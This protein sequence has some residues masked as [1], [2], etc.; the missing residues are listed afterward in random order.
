VVGEHVAPLRS[1]RPNDRA[2][3]DTRI[4]MEHLAE[5]VRRIERVLRR[6]AD[7]PLAA[8]RARLQVLSGSA[9]DGQGEGNCPSVILQ[10]TNPCAARITVEVQAVDLWWLLVADGPGTEFYVRMPDDRYALLARLCA[11]VIAGRYSHGPLDGAWQETFK[12]LDG[13]F[14]SSHRGRFGIPPATQHFARY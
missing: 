12:W 13:D 4:A 9:P 14:S 11:S 5:T 3:L 1:G 2:R 6:V 10:P 8:G 7:E